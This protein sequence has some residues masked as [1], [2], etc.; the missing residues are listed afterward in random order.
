M[1]LRHDRKKEVL[2]L[3][4]YLGILVYALFLMRHPY[5]KPRY[6]LKPFR[7]LIQIIT[8]DKR[9]LR[10]R[11]WA[12]QGIVINILIFVPLGYLLP[13]IWKWVDRWWK[14]IIMGFAVSLGIELLQ[15]VTK[16]G[17][18]DIDDLINNTIGSVIGWG[19][20]LRWLKE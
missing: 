11:K 3:T 17:M 8:W 18:Y 13:L 5:L 20:Y 7:A 6:A 1:F 14:V 15:L 19:C 2:V 12:Y 10:I 4:V 9:G 16:L